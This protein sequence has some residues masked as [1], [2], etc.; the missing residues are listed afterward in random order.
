MVKT[1]PR[2][3]YNAMERFGNMTIKEIEHE[4]IRSKNPEPGSIRGWRNERWMR[5][6]L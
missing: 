3:K 4:K 6:Y 2:G 5:P 1:S